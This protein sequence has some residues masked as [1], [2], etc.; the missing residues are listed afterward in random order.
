MMTP[1]LLRPILT[2][3]CCL[4]VSLISVS[5]SAKTLVLAQ[6]SDRPKKDYRQLRP[7]AEYIQSLMSEQGYDRADVELYPDIESLMNAVR[8]GRVHWV[9]ETALTSAQLVQAG[10]ATPLA[11]KWKRGQSQYRS[12]IYVRKDSPVHK[13][14][15]LQ[16]R[17]IAFEHSN[18]FSSYYVPALALL[19][20]GMTLQRLETPDTPIDSEHVGYLFSRNERNNLLWVHKQIVSAGSLNDGDWNRPDRLPSE[21]KQG[22]R[23]IYQS[24]AYPRAFELAT[25]ALSAQDRLA[26]QQALLSLNPEQHAPILE[27]YEQTERLTPATDEHL[28]LL[29]Q[30]DLELL[31]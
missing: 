13:L 8:Q 4:A 15:D 20:A 19:N 17:T 31:P 7:M 10:L 9:S 21:P 28:R 25:S 30:L 22:M 24:D 29:Q 1:N 14:Q 16:G 11:L 23:I 26:L 5:A 2:L 12:L 18:S 6:I 3:L 27:R